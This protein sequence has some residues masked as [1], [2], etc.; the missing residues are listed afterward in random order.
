MGNVTVTLHDSSNFVL[1]DETEKQT[2][3]KSFDHP[4]NIHMHGMKLRFN[5]TTRAELD[6]DLLVVKLSLPHLNFVM[7]IN[8][9]MGVRIP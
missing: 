1:M 6:A 5:L 9:I 8:R 2:L 4:C 7:G 3:R